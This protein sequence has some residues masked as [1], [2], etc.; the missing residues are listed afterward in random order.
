MTYTLTG[1]EYTHQSSCCSDGRDVGMHSSRWCCR[2]AY[3]KWRTCWRS[4]CASTSGRRLPDALIFAIFDGNYG[5]R[6][7]YVIIP[8]PSL[9]ISCHILLHNIAPNYPTSACDPTHRNIALLTIFIVLPSIS[10]CISALL[11]PWS[12]A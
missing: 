8:I 5:P 12:V 2:A 6:V 11:F 10:Y 1:F 7:C 3:G 4:V 9:I